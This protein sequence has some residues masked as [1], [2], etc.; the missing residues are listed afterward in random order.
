MRRHMGF[1][2]KEFIE[3]LV[4]RESR[5]I[6]VSQSPFP[7]AP[8]VITR[9]LHEFRHRG[10]AG[11]QRPFGLGIPAG[12]RPCPVCTPVINAHR[13]GPQTVHPAYMLV[14]RIPSAA[15]RSIFGVLISFCP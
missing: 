5:G 1:V 4:R 15:I 2:P 11:L 13:D 6:V 7:H 9:L 14:N 3:P 8:G 10:V 12:M